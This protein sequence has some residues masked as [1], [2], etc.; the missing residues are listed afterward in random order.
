MRID[1]SFLF[2]LDRF[3]CDNG[4]NAMLIRI[5]KIEFR[6]NG[7]FLYYSFGQKIFLV[8]NYFHIFFSQLL[9]VFQL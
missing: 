2:I 9:V 6:Y 5:Y 1:F 7:R 8:K 4:L 3:G